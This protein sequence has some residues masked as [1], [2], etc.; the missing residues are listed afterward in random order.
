M[1]GLRQASLI[2][3]SRNRLLNPLSLLALAMLVGACAGQDDD[4]TALLQQLD[5]GI[6]HGIALSADQT[7]QIE[8]LRGQ[9]Q[10]M[11]SDDKAAECVT[12]AKKALGII[13]AVGTSG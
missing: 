7:S 3:M 10:D 2:P 6:A 1:S 5:E 12:V 13:Q 8:M 9:A 4:C 11:L